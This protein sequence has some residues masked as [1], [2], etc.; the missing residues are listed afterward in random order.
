MELT[1]HTLNNDDGWELDLKQFHRPDVLRKDRRPVVMIPGYAMNTFILSFHPSGRSMVEYLVD[2][3]FEVWTANLRGQGDSRR[4]GGK[5]SWGLGQLALHDLPTVLEKVRLDTLT[6]QDEVDLV[7][8]SLGASMVYAFLAH[9]P[10][11]HGV[12][13]VVAMGGPL[14]WEAVHPLMAAAFRNAAVVSTLRF[15]GTRRLAEA[16]LRLVRVVPP[17]QR[18]LHIYMNPS[19]IDLRAG[20]DMVQTVD[21]PVP[22]INR[23]IARWMRQKDLYVRG[24]NVTQGMAEVQVPVLCVLANA[25]GIV[26]VATA[27]SVRQVLGSE[28]VS[29]LEVG[30]N[31]R[32]F[33]H[34][35]LFVSRDAEHKVF[36]PMAR[37]LESNYTS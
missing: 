37:W 35:D 1:R 20:S 3:G 12:G 36:E 11:S 24:L 6:G 26:P 7:G 14:R 13:A 34:A 16:A 29:V 25:D 28:L 22:Y 27:L 33:A 18:L 2:Q 8:C 5:R 17:L 15:R 9:H 4:V 32:W 23:Q 19:Q 31:E 21:D 10:R 30:D